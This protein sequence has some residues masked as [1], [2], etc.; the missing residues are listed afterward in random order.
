[1]TSPKTR[2]Q[3]E[4]GDDIV[5]IVIVAVIVEIFFLLLVYLSLY[6]YSPIFVLNSQYDTWQLHNTLQLKCAPPYCTPEEMEKLNN[7]FI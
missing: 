3:S 6:L 7:S 5:I 4:K 2:L 1:M